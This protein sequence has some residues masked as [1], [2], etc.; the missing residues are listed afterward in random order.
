[1][2]SIGFQSG[3]LGS[4]TL[5]SGTV[6]EWMVNITWW[7]LRYAQR[8]VD[9]TRQGQSSGAGNRS[10][11]AGVVDYSAEVVFLLPTTVDTTGAAANTNYGF[12]DVEVKLLHNAT[13]G[14]RFNALLHDYDIESPLDGPTVG[15][16]R[17]TGLS[18]PA[19]GFVFVG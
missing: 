16:A 9:T 3:Y 1:M 5:H 10:V 11:I 6:P 15:R 12:R 7:R 19:A 18:D 4:I 2:A 13:Q 17:F 8:I 14:Y